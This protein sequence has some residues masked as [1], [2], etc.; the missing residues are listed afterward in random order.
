[1]KIFTEGVLIL[2]SA[3]ALRTEYHNKKFNYDFP[4]GLNDLLSDHRIIALTTNNGN[5]ILVEFY[6][7]QELPKS[8]YSKQ[9]KQF[10]R[11]QEFD[12]LLVLSHADFTMLCNKEGKTELFSWP[13][14]KIQ[15][16]K[17]SIY[18]VSIGIEDTTNNYE[19]YGVYFKISIA[20]NPVA[21]SDCM[22]NILDVAD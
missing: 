5:N 13:I 15:N 20:L 6:I 8:E 3:Q 19:K 4:E 17:S 7:D 9:I 16:L 12:E 10:I 1:M 21:Q 22:N 11:I 14:K 2:A 18:I